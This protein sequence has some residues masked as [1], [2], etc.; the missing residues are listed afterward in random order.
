MTSWLRSFRELILPD[1]I[2]TDTNIGRITSY[3]DVHNDVQSILIP[4]T[5]P[6]GI[7][8]HILQSLNKSFA[9]QHK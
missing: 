5:V 6:K 4:P 3:E 7:S 2:D 9:V 8:V 1:A